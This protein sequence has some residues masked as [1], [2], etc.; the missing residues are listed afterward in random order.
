[1]S[2]VAQNQNRLEV[3]GAQTLLLDWPS[4]FPVCFAKLRR[5]W[6]AAP[7]RIRPVCGKTRHVIGQSTTKSTEKHILSM[8][9]KKNERQGENMANK[10]LL[11]SDL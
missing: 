8:H 10:E 7:G 6:A 2:G 9:K 3:A 4:A 11:R 5:H 1:M